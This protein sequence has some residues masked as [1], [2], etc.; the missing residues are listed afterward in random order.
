[1]SVLEARLEARSRRSYEMGRLTHAGIRVLPLVPLMA[2]ALLGCSPSHEVIACA[3]SLLVVVTLLLWRGQEWE[4]GVGPGIAAGLVPLLFPICV[5]AVGHLCLPGSCL[6]LPTVCAAGGLL[7]GF[8]LG[9]VAPRP[10]IGR[11]IPFIV[12]CVVACLMGAVGCL[13]YGLVGLAVMAAGMVTGTAGLV[14]LRRA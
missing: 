14:V 8:L 12:A 10:R 9:V 13:L 3:G 6:L 4:M 2:L 1:M 7:G 11:M 5:Q